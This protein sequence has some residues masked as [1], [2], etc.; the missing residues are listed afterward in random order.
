[1]D[2]ARDQLLAGARLAGDE[3]AGIGA[4]NL[5]HQTEDLLDVVAFADDVFEA[6]LVAQFAA[7]EAVL[8]EQRLLRQRVAH[9]RL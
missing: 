1:M 3:H 7:Q 2:R 4:R 5:L 8:A 9:H 6:I